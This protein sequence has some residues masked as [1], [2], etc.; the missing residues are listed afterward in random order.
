MGMPTDI[1]IIDTSLNLPLQETQVMGK[2]VEMNKRLGEVAGVRIDDRHWL[3]LLPIR[4][5][6]EYFYA[7][8]AF[9]HAPRSWR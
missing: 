6:W 3:I 8:A 1:A 5:R 9:S 7:T 2:M 4:S